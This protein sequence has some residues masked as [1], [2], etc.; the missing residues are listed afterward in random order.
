MEPTDLWLWSFAPDGRS[1]IA[2][3]TIDGEKRVVI[4]P[5]DQAAALSV[6]DMQLRD[7]SMELS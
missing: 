3:G 7:G 6:L 5:V 2:V 4:R 1:L